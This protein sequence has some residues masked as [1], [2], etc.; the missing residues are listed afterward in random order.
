LA[1]SD[2]VTNFGEIV[3]VIRG[4]G[5]ENDEIRIH[6]RSYLAARLRFAEASGWSGGEGCENLHRRKA[7]L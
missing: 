5:A 4:V 2:G 3:C 6:S 1:A 7:G